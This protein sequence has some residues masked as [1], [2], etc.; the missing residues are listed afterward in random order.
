MNELQQVKAWY[1]DDLI[2]RFGTPQFARFAGRSSGFSELISG[3]P[4]RVQVGKIDTACAEH[5]DPCIVHMP[6]WYLTPAVFDL[7][8]TPP[9]S[10]LGQIAMGIFNGTLIH[11]SNHLQWS[12]PTIRDIM[13]YCTLGNFDDLTDKN[14]ARMLVNIVEDI[15]ID[16]RFIRED[17][18]GFFILFKN[19]ALFD[20]KPE[21]IRNSIISA[22]RVEWRY[23]DELWTDFPQVQ[24]LLQEAEFAYETE[25]RANIAWQ[26]Y[27]LIFEEAQEDQNEPQF[28]GGDGD[29][30]FDAPF[31]AVEGSDDVELTMSHK[32]ML[33]VEDNFNRAEQGESDNAIDWE[34]LFVD[35]DDWSASTDKPANSKFD[36]FGR[37]LRAQ[38]QQQFLHGRP[39][40]KGKL[41]RRQLHR[42]GTDGKIFHKR[43]QLQ[44]KK[45]MEVILL[46]DLSGSTGWHYTMDGESL[47]LYDHI[48]RAAKGAYTSLWRAGI[49]CQVFAHTSEEGPRDRPTIYTIATRRGQEENFN[50]A[51]SIRLQNNYDGVAIRETSAF[52]K[53]PRATRH[54]IVWSDGEPAGYGEYSGPDAVRLTKEEVAW[55][56]NQGISVHSVSLV[57]EVVSACD[58]I[59]GVASNVDASLNLADE[60]KTK[61]V[62]IATGANHV[63]H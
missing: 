28:G 30:D 18:A 23:D 53:N 9:V 4:T 54:L 11:E 16:A 10:H 8:E 35:I 12:P 34:V 63:T 26:I 52:F 15:Y 46:L 19:Q 44:A 40:D 56:R 32:A 45:P 49:P 33:K 57:K 42:Y 58:E 24:E 31:T 22:K 14:L 48:L 29:G 20:K 60:I 27:H 17:F 37:N 62:D 36:D 6:T 43:T 47:H 5:G 13:E 3:R 55:V 51:Y 2:P 41:A 1:R 39:E 38:T 7:F 61:I 25:E 59:Y 50:K 21:G